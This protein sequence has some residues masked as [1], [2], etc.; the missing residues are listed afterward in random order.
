M[1]LS[2]GIGWTAAMLSVLIVFAVISDLLRPLLFVAIVL[3]MTGMGLVLAK[4]YRAGAIVQVLAAGAAFPHALATV[5]FM[6]YPVL[7]LIGARTAYRYPALL[8]FHVESP[9]GEEIFG[10]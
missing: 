2:F 6:P 3:Q 4:Q 9:P 1:R 10:A 5:W 7:G 8:K